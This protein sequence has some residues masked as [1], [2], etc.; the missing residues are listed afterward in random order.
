MDRPERRAPAPTLLTLVGTVGAVVAAIAAYGTAGA[1]TVEEGLTIGSA[2]GPAEESFQR[3]NELE[4]AADGRIVVVDEGTRLVLVF[5]RHGRFLL[6]FGGKGEGPAEF[7]DIGAS[8]LAGDTL[9]VLDTE[10]MKLAYFGLDGTLLRTRRM[11][12]SV[13]RHG[14]PARMHALRGGDLVLEGTSGCTPPLPREGEDTQWRLLLIPADS[15]EP[16]VLRREARGDALVVYTKSPPVSCSVLDLPFE[17]A[18]RMTVGPDGLIAFGTGAAPQ[19]EAYRL[20][21]ATAGASDLAG[22]PAR[23]IPLPGVRRPLTR[24]DRRAWAERQLAL[25]SGPEKFRS[26]RLTNRFREVI[27]DIK[28][29]DRWPAY[30][31]LVLDKA[32]VLWVRRPPSVDDAEATWDVLRADGTRL[33]QATVPA[34][35]DVH[36]IVDGRIYGVLK[37][38]WDEDL[39]KTF[40]VRWDR[41]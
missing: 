9:V 40:V 19:V 41:R 5:D 26:G 15:T 39:V 20:P 3:I 29:P 1:Q 30:D 32:G 23:S 31:R 28:F 2:M 10:N 7:E 37:G 4:V 38:E 22:P 8:A 21:V 17:A 33:G 34:A 14:F 35:L 25:R 27:D 11:G 24:S 12:F 36:A 18:P 13:F 16:I 6:Q